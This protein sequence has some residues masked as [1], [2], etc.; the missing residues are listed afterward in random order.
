VAELLD[1]GGQPWCE[2]RAICLRDLDAARLVPGFAVR[3]AIHFQ[4]NWI[5]LIEAARQLEDDGSSQLKTGIEQYLL[6]PLSPAIDEAEQRLLDMFNV[7]GRGGRILSDRVADDPFWGLA[8]ERWEKEFS[9]ELAGEAAQCEPS[10]IKKFLNSL[11][12]MTPWAFFVP[13][14]VALGQRWSNLSHLN[15]PDEWVA[16]LI[17][18]RLT[19]GA[20]ERG[21]SNSRNVPYKQPILSREDSLFLLL[22]QLSESGWIKE[23]AKLFRAI[24]GGPGNESWRKRESWRQYVKRRYAQ[25]G[26]YRDRV[27]RWNFHTLVIPFPEEGAAFELGSDRSSDAD[28]LAEWLVSGTC[29]A[30]LLVLAGCDPARYSLTREYQELVRQL[31]SPQPG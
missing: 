6:K 9:V 8:R 16:T 14:V 7:E 25:V 24:I 31:R 22:E 30:R 18:S 5:A 15:L 19:W 27:K 20:G 29:D 10:N 3:P 1:Y 28:F 4:W 11:R 2:V 12:Q 26:R 17:L 13:E 23:P 21:T